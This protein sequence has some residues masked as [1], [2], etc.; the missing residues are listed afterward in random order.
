MAF[1]LMDSRHL[2]LLLNTTQAQQY[3]EMCILLI[4][5]MERFLF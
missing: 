5:S 3:L 4:K 1:L 2:P